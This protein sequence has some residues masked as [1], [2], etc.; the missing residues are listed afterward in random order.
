[1]LQARIATRLNGESLG[2]AMCEVGMRTR[3]ERALT[4]S[5]AMENAV[6]LFH[7]GFT[8]EH[9]GDEWRVYLRGELR[10]QFVKAFATEREA[11]AFVRARHGPY[12]DVTQGER[13]D[14]Q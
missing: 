12:V 9:A 5:R 4:S 10:R 8:V 6:E 7:P 14:L 1:M 13:T 3:K 2:V 11:E